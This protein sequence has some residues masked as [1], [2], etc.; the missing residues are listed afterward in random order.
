MKLS[1][2][3]I[4]DLHRDPEHPIGNHALLDSLENDLRRYTSEETPRVRPPDI[5]IVSGDVI[6]GVSPKDPEPEKKLRGQYAEALSFL[7]DLTRRLANG[8]KRRVII[9]PG[10]H[11]VSAYHFMKSIERI[12]IVADRKKQ[13]V[14]QLFSPSSLLRWSWVDFE[15]FEIVKADIYADRLAAFSDFYKEFYE[16]ARTYSLDPAQQFDIFDFV[17][18]N[19]T[20]A[21]FCSCYNNDIFNKQGAI[22]PDCIAGAG[23][24]LRDTFY[25][26]RLRIAVWHHNTEGVPL[27]VDYMDPDIL[28]NLIDRGVSIGF[29]GHQHRPQFLDTRFRHE[30]SRRITVI[31][32]GT[33]CGDASLGFRRS[34]NV[35]EL[36]TERRTGWLHVREMLNDNLQLP[37]WGRRPLPPN[38][39]SYLEFKFDPSPEPI[40]RAD[41]G[42]LALVAAQ[43]HF[44]AGE[45]RQAVD[46]LRPFAKSDDLARRLLLECHLQLHDNLAILADFDPP[47]S[48]AEAVH[49]MDALWAEGKQDGLRRVLAEPLIANA[50]DPSIVEM[51]NKYAARLKT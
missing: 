44:N 6:H 5:V 42:T 24:A 41:A 22:H 10:N 15:L 12:D 14:T 20:I 39:K 38:V 46:G 4:S 34:Y 28:Q 25:D 23:R 36:D 8:D 45:Y 27:Q 1:V 47:K 7:N 51:R 17:D 31:S 13:L 26:N 49:L 9:I 30:G 37:I 29:H 50:S 2:L 40:V 21:G 19:L 3:H 35:V 33:L 32:A 16:G 18:F 43:N 11:D 48:L